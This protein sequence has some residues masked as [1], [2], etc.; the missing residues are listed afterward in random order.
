MH[1]RLCCGV[2]S[3]AEE[4]KSFIFYLHPAL[5]GPV[6]ADVDSRPKQTVDDVCLDLKMAPFA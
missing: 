5:A 2:T 4:Q 6:V 1:R 3:A